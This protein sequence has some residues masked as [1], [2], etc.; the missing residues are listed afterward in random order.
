MVVHVT[1]RFSCLH[2]LIKFFLFTENP[3]LCMKLNLTEKLSI[4]FKIFRDAVRYQFTHEILSEDESVWKGETIPRDR[5]I[6]LVLR[7]QP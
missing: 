6:S 1:N 2:P 5:R 4:L 3:F 7:C